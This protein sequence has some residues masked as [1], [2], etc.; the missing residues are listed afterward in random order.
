M[1]RAMPD[2]PDVVIA[3]Q[4]LDQLKSVGFQFRRVAPGEDGPLVGH[5]INGECVD[6]VHLEGFSRDCFAW[7]PRAS[8]LIVSGTP[9]VQRQVDG[10]ALTVLNEVLSW[11]TAP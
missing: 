8:S 6:L 9:L 7:R 3:K 1:W 4:L 10:G 5:R 2:S 11:Q